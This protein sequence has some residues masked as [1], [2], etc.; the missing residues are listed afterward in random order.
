[1][2]HADLLE[3]DGKL[4]FTI[5]VEGTNEKTIF[6][7]KLQQE[8]SG[9]VSIEHLDMGYCYAEPNCTMRLNGCYSETTCDYALYVMNLPGS[10]E[11]E[12]GSCI[13]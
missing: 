2:F 7:F 13:N 11:T 4:T 3:E 5:N 1:M 12:D 10:F 8:D 9:C 6:K